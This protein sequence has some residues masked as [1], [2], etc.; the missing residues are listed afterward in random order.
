MKIHF[1]FLGFIFFCYQVNAQHEL[2]AFTATG[3][4][5]AST[6]FNT[7]YHAIG[8]NPANLGLKTIYETKKVTFGLSEMAFSAYTGAVNKSRFK[9]SI[10]NFGSENFSF[11]DKRQAVSEFSDAGT[12]LNLD[13]VPIGFA[14][15]MDGFGGIAFSVRENFRWFSSFGQRAADIMFLGKTA[16]YFQTLELQDG[17]FVPNDPAQYEAYG[18][19]DNIKRGIATQPLSLATLLEGTSIKNHW[20]REFNLSY[21]RE[22][23]STDLFLLTAG[24]GLKMIRGFQ[25][26]DVQAKD[27][28]LTA[29][30]AFNPLFQIDFGSPTANNPSAIM[31]NDYQAIGR[32]FGADLGATFVYDEKIKAAIAV[33]N[34]GSVTYTGN[35][36]TVRDTTLYS[37]SS[38]GINSYNIFYEAANVISEAGLLQW[39]GLNSVKVKLPT[40]L[41]VGASYVLEDKA[42]VGFDVVL[43]L[44]TAAGNFDRPVIALGGDFKPVRWIRLSTGMAWGG[45]TKSKANIPFGITF[46]AGENGTWEAGVASRDIITYISQSGPHYSLAFGFFRFRI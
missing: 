31:N 17:S 36:Y 44:N 32:G 24:V 35:V 1:L 26:I 8:I 29:V 3:R 40:M 11:E 39:S 34:I 46:V 13:I 18:G 2:G 37:L 45:N 5:G 28:V 9:S 27:G 43:P 20:Y 38:E 16:T 21:G 23:F 10:T 41:R 7:D 4:A 19:L 6:S 22:V 25:Y 14:F 12:A 15:Q 30:G 33:T 42:E